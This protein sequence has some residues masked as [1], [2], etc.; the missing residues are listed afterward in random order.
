MVLDTKKPA[1]LVP[2]GLLGLLRMALE[3]SLKNFGGAGG[4]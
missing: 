1:G 4:S 3:P 2:Y